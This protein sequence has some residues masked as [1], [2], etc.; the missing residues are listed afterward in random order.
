MKYLAVLLSLFPSVAWAD[1]CIT[2]AE[3][4]KK[5][6]SMSFRVIHSGKTLDE[7]GECK[8][9]YA[10]LSRHKVGELIYQPFEQ[11]SDAFPEVTA[12]HTLGTTTITRRVFDQTEATEVA[13]ERLAISYISDSGKSQQTDIW[14]SPV[15]GIILK[16]SERRSNKTM[17]IQYEYNHLDNIFF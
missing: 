1:G 5:H 10:G 13:V 12:C 4:L 2:A 9:V 17:N 7:N 15:T 16:R 3:A 8:S 11:A 14:I 6:S